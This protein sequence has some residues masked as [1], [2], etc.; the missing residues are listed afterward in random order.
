ML[1]V[2]LN[3]L[4]S[5]IESDIGAFFKSNNLETPFLIVLNPSDLDKSLYFSVL[6]GT[7]AS[8]QV[9]E[10]IQTT[11]RASR[12]SKFKNEQ[13]VDYYI[14]TLTKDTIEDMITVFKIKGYL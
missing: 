2:D 12:V 6:V 14:Y 11:Y 7:A 13:R 5:A 4:K 9:D 10:Y 3:Q 8:K 1:S